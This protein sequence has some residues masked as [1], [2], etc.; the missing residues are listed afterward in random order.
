MLQRMEPSRLFCL[1]LHAFA[2]LVPLPRYLHLV[3]VPQFVVIA[4]V[5]L[6][7]SLYLLLILFRDCL[8]WRLVGIVIREMGGRR[9]EE[10][11]EG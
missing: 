5:L 3:I 7:F 4:A 9:E 10:R 8:C 2:R 11:R 1:S 6:L